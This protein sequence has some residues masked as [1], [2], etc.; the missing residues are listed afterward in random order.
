MRFFW[1][2]P[3]SHG[4]VGV[5]GALLSVAAHA[6][7]LGA[8]MYGTGPSSTLLD[9]TTREHLFYL[10]PPDRS[11]GRAATVEHLQYVQL[12]SGQAIAAADAPAEDPAGQPDARRDRRHGGVTGEEAKE[13][14][15]SAPLDSPDSV[16]SVLS[17]DQSAQRVDGSAAP[18]YPPEMLAQGMEGVVR[19]RYVIDTTGRADSVSL[20]VLDS[21]NEAFERAVRAAVPGMRF[22]PAAV[23]GR[24]VRQ[25]VEQEFQ[26]RITLPT[27]VGAPAEHTSTNPVP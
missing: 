16:Y 7:F 8:A 21:S 3:A 19:T 6:A 23:S 14:M 17:L 2:H 5:P 10:P 26:F 13:Q 22:S 4:T 15:V 1:F 9:F 24:R 12:G 11:P 27:P 18:T 25:I 20:Q